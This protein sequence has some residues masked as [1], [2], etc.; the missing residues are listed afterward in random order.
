ML[1]VT[2][3]RKIATLHGSSPGSRCTQNQLLMCFENHSC[4][5]CN[6]YF[7]VFSV[8]ESTRKLVSKHVARYKASKKLDPSTKPATYDFPPEPAD[9]C[10][11][12]TILFKAC[13]K[14]Q[15]KYLQEEGCAVCGE[16][17]SI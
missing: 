12:N 9:A 13:K 3:A 5:R 10:L 1:P 2:H 15:P 16:L 7:T 6:S 8:E 17:K 11:I 14:M 4:L